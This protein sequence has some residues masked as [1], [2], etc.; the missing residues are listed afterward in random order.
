MLRLSHRN[1]GN[2]LIRGGLHIKAVL[3]RCPR[4]EAAFEKLAIQSMDLICILYLPQVD[5]GRYDIGEIEVGFLQIVQKIA[6]GLSQLQIQ[7]RRNNP[8]VGDEPAFARHI[9]GVAVENAGAGGRTGRARLDPL[10]R[11]TRQALTG[12]RSTQNSTRLLISPSWASSSGLRGRL[13]A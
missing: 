4:G 13:S 7:V 10:K 8:L 3:H 6:H 5:R 11:W 2:L 1:H 9:V 12:E